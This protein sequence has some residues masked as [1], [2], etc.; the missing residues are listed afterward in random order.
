[1]VSPP[2][3]QTSPSLSDNR[4][5]FMC[6]LQTDHRQVLSSLF[7]GALAGALA[8]TAVAPLDRTKII[9]QGKSCLSVCPSVIELLPGSHPLHSFPDCTVKRSPG[10]AR[11]QY[12]TPGSLEPEFIPSHF[13]GRSLNRGAGRVGPFWS[14]QEK[15]LS[16]LWG[17]QASLAC[18]R[19]TPIFASLL[20]CV[21]SSHEDTEHSIRPLAYSLGLI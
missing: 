21:L 5:V 9:F 10:A 15:S 12:H 14:V 18:G 6:F 17:R 13:Q 20:A 4:R 8:K 7:S 16:Q 19:I 3:E 1:M 11:T 2:G